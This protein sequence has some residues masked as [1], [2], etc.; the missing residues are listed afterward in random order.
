MPANRVTVFGGTGFLGR[1]IV[2]RLARAGIEVIVAARHARDVAVPEASGKVVFRRTDVRDDASLAA[3]LEGADAAVNAVSLY[4]ERRG[5]G[6][7]TIHVEAATRLARLAAEK[8]TGLVHI[9]GIGVDEASDSAYVRARARGE[10]AVRETHPGAVA[11]RPSVL[12][13]PDDAF[14]SSLAMLARLPLV[15][16]FGHGAT[17]LQP[18]HVNDV[19]EAVAR[20]LAR[21]ITGEVIELGGAGVHRYRELVR[22]AQQRHGQHHQL[23]PVPFSLWRALTAPLAVLPEPPLTRDQVILMESDN[24]VGRDATTFA[25]LGIEPRDIVRVSFGDRD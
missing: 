18:V 9:S 11:L 23:L 17:R 5:L 20:V 21:D 3:A 10:R 22:A 8:R 4:V 19:A 25:R 2:M 12:F 14:A 6:F 7:T 13:G 15:P 24:I 1:R 16:L